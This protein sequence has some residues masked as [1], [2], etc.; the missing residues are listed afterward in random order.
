MPLSPGALGASWTALGE[1]L[2]DPSP[3]LGYGDGQVCRDEWKQERASLPWRRCLFELGPAVLCRWALLLGVIGCSGSPHMKAPG[4][5]CGGR[6]P[7]TRRLCLPRESWA[8]DAGNG[9][10]ST[11]GVM[12]HVLRLGDFTDLS[13]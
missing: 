11:L 1:W 8:G 4:A 3:R 9:H 7:G 12:G 10:G 2:G 13:L 5:V 6:V